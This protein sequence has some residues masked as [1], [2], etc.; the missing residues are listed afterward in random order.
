MILM[1]PKVV[2]MVYTSHN[3]E[4][5]KIVATPVAG[6]N[7]KSKDLQ[8]E[9]TPC[10]DEGAGLDLLSEKCGTRVAALRWSGRCCALRS[11][12]VKGRRMELVCTQ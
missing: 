11:R 3:A 5:C 1:D 2:Q 10:L 4:Q 12:P 6:L 8:Q 9:Q 7:S